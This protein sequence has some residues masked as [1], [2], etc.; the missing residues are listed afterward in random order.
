[1]SKDVKI[2]NSCTMPF[3]IPIIKLNELIII[4][5]DIQFDAFYGINDIKNEGIAIKTINEFISKNNLPISL[6]GYDFIQNTK[7][8]DKKWSVSYDLNTYTNTNSDE[9]HAIISGNK[10]K[11]ERVFWYRS[12]K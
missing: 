2:K 11:F 3:T 8:N 9:K 10:S 6:F 12:E 1:M 4:D 5:N 7:F